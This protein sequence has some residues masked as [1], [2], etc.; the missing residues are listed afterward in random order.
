MRSMKANRICLT[1]QKKREILIK[2][3]IDM[4]NR[5]NTSSLHEKCTK[6][7]K[8]SDILLSPRS[9]CSGDLCSHKVCQSCFRKEN[10]NLRIGETHTYKCPCCHIPFYEYMR[11]IGEAILIGEANTLF[12]NIAPTLLSTSS[13]ILSRENVINTIEMNDLVIAKVEA[14]L[15]LN[16]TSFDTLY[17]LFLSHYQ[18]HNFLME[19]EISNSPQESYAL[20]LFDY[21][22]KVLNHPTVLVECLE[23][24]KCDCCYQLAGIFYVYNNFSAALKYSKF[25]YEYC[26]RYSDHANMPCCK[27]L[28]LKSRAAFAKLPPLRFAVG[29]EV[30]FL[31][32]LETGREWKQGKV[33]EHCYREGDF[34]ITFNAPYRLQLLYDPDSVDQPPVYAWVKADLDRYVRKVGVKSIED[35]RYQARLEAKVEELAH[36]Y[37]S[38]DIMYDIYVALALDHEFVEMLRSVWHIELSESVIHKYRLLVMYRQ[39]LIRTD[40]GYHMPSSEEVIAGIK[41]FFDPIHLSGDAALLAA[42]KD[43]HSVEIRTDILNML[44]EVIPN[45][46]TCSLGCVCGSDIQRHLIRGIRDYI[47]AFSPAD[48]SVYT[49]ELLHQSSSFSVPLEL[50]NAISRVSTTRDLKSMLVKGSFETKVAHYIAAWTALH[51]CLENPSAGT[52]RECPFVYFF[53]KYCLDRGFGVPKLALDMYDRM[54]MQLSREFIRCANPTCELN[55]LD[56][57]TGQVKFKKCSRCQAV[58]YCSRECQIAHY[59]EHKRL[60]LEHSTG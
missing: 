21:A 44:R 58:I 27:A 37:C 52:S 15:L 14:A 18:T 28:Y 24:V 34:P 19:H 53:V 41:A 46:L 45:K 49:T 29:D 51:A 35:T 38:K 13:T 31:H 55:R 2:L 50:S 20:K 36:V 7:R 57:S 12:K 8:E 17:F 43:G 59:P 23:K 56:Q 48:S 30:E 33:V 11:S 32:E 9:R 40:S 10:I 39:P 47:E 54:N 42:D 5:S 16:P 4:K 60:C 1:D 22:F 26:L 6:C 3:D 25:A